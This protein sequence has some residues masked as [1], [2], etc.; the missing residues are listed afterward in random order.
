[1]QQKKGRAANS[2]YDRIA[3][4]L[5]RCPAIQSFLFQLR[6]RFNILLRGDVGQIPE[7]SS[8]S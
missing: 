3:C 8:W 4:V 7:A 2:I 1:M 6:D 5:S